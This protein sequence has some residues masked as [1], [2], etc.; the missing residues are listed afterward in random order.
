MISKFL[1]KLKS[2]LFKSPASIE[3]P[4]K[5]KPTNQKSL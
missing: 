4:K 5:E 1:S 2:I 3:F